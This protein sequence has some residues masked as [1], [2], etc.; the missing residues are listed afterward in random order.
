M[1][2]VIEK[3]HKMP[4]LRKHQYSNAIKVLMFISNIKSYIPIKICNTTGSIH[5]FKLTVSLKREDIR[6]CRNK[7]WDI[8]EID[9]KHIIVTVNGNVINVP[10]SVIIPF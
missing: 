1:F 6:L 2:L 4:I 5:L 9:W 10:S 7:V 8:L 3:M